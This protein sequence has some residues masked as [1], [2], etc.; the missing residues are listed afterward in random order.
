MAKNREDTLSTEVAP[1]QVVLPVPVPDQAKPTIDLST[2]QNKETQLSKDL[3]AETDKLLS[4]GVKDAPK[5]Y[6]DY[7][8]AWKEE[9]Q[10]AS[11][12][13]SRDTQRQLMLAS[14]IGQVAI[15]ILSKDMALL[16][17]ATAA[18][19]DSALAIDSDY[20]TDG[21]DPELY[22]SYNLDDA[23]TAVLQFQ[24]SLAPHGV[25]D[26]NKGDYVSGLVAQLVRALLAVYS[27][28]Q[29][30]FNGRKE[31]N[32]EVAK[33]DFRKLMGVSE[34]I[35]DSNKRLYS[36]LTKLATTGGSRKAPFLLSDIL[37]SD[38]GIVDKVD[39][40]MRML[41]A[42]YAAIV[43]LRLVSVALAYRQQQFDRDMRVKAYDRACP[44]QV[45]P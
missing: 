6:A 37:E 19:V 33:S 44:E 14:N 25:K 17:H 21:Y 26:Y 34:Q 35:T 3:V 23:M 20:G 28:A 27:E 36:G 40:G 41:Y 39:S 32:A 43:F 30:K 16:E 45:R 8:N 9:P 4:L 7:V 42:F 22:G 31:S 10:D 13:L 1:A 11:N 24:G 18:S 2:Q 15:A 29:I 38:M 12:F 5:T